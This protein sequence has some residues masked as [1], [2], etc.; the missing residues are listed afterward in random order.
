MEFVAATNNAHKLKEMRR[1]LERMGH[2]VLSQ[3]EAGVSL[4]PEENGT[5]FSEDVYKRQGIDR[6]SNRSSSVGEC[7]A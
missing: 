5:T 2:T 6:S 3:K 7:A 1:I 4:D